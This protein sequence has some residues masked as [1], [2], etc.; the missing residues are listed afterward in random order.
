MT[1]W[2]VIKKAGKAA[3]GPFL[4]LALIVYFGLNLVQGDRGLLAWMRLDREV[5]VAGLRLADSNAERQRLE[6]RASL[7]KADHLDP[8]MLDERARAAL[9]LIGPNEQVIF[10]PA[11]P[12]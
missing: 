3:I 12:H 9:N 1:I 6:H 7:M 5:R 8:D 4:A 11:D 10:L 2:R